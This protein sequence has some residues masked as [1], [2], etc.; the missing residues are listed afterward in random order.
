MRST[1]IYELFVFI[2]KLSFGFVATLYVPYLLEEIGLSYA[3]IS[4][5]NMVF[6][7][8]IVLA[9]IPTGMLADGRGRGWSLKIGTLFTAAGGLLLLFVT[10]IW[11]A[12]AAEVAFGIGFAFLSGARTS[13]IA[14]APDRTESVERIYARAT[15][16]GAV[17]SL[18]GVLTGGQ[19]ALLF[20]R[21]VGYLGLTVGFAALAVVAAKLMQGR[22]P[23]ERLK[24]FDA[25]RFS[26]GHLRRSAPMRWITC[27]QFLVG[28]IIVFNLYWTPLA[29]TQLSQ[30]QLSYAWVPMYLAMAFAGW[31]VF[32]LSHRSNGTHSKQ[33]GY[34]PIVLSVVAIFA[35]LAFVSLGQP[36][37]QMIVIFMLHEAGRGAFP[38][39]KDAFLDTRLKSSYRATFKSLSSFIGSSGMI[40]TSGAMA[41]FM[42]GRENDPELIVTLWTVTGTA[43]VSLV[44]LAYLVRPRT[45][46]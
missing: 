30:V 5:I 3:D 42:S 21:R 33:V 25:L 35:S 8:T 22:E 6:W 37:W 13:W 34:L 28:A 44:T 2:E 41:L 26:V 9:E 10:N 4:A 16:V 12:I 17:A 11:I 18:I 39:L 24:E 38:P 40:F 1:R 15:V 43:I 45:E 27:V 19:L 14:D 20:G 46:T 31:L 7:I 36:V 23:E 32:K 29:L